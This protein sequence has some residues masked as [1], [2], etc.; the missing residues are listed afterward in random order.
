MF[1]SLLAYLNSLFAGTS[2][3]PSSNGPVDTTLSASNTSYTAPS[4]LTSQVLTITG[5]NDKVI[6]NTATLVVVA[7]GNSDAVTSS[8][9]SVTFVAEGSQDSLTLTT[10]GANAILDLTDATGGAAAATQLTATQATATL[11]N[12]TYSCNYSVCYYCGPVPYLNVNGDNNKIRLGNYSMSLIVNGVSDI[13][14]GGSGATTVTTG[15]NASGDVILGGSGAM[16]VSSAAAGVN[17]IGGTGTMNVKLTGNYDNLVTGP[18]TMVATISSIGATIETGTGNSTI[19]LTGSYATVVSGTGST[20]VVYTDATGGGLFYEGSASG[21]AEFDVA[22]SS[23]TLYG[24]DVVNA[25]GSGM[26]IMSQASAQTDLGGS[27]YSQLQF[28]GYGAAAALLPDADISAALIAAA[29]IFLPAGVTIPATTGSSGSTSSNC[30]QP[31]C[32]SGGGSGGGG[33]SNSASYRIVSLNGSNS[34]VGSDSRLMFVTVN[35]AS[36]SLYGGT[37]G[38]IYWI[39]SGELNKY[40]AGA[41]NNLIVGDGGRNVLEYFG[42]ANPVTVNIAAGTAINGYGGVDSIYNM[43]WAEIGAN[44]TA[45]G[46][47]QDATL[48]AFGSNSTL[49]GG[50]GN[51][52]LTGLGDSDTLIA[53]SGADTLNTSGQNT[54]FVIG[55]SGAIP[56]STVINSGVVGATGALS[57]L[58]AVQP[59]QIWLAADKA[60]DLVIDILGTAKS[61]TVDNWFAS[62]TQL[63]SITAAGKTLTN[64]AINSL[65]QAMASYQAAHATFDPTKATALPTDSGIQAAYAWH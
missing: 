55:K 26:R 18:G 21:Y 57:F 60:G 33:S 49:Q 35:G 25:T 50:S 6:D 44:S 48:T 58:A 29:P 56:Q 14:V 38:Q 37:A 51:D 8:S 40:F 15:A 52:T 30:C 16:T 64:A 17:V 54:S 9:T 46:G 53:G 62:G 41:G 32:G 65:E 5:S 23:S 47:R 19:N 42:A 59:G 36:N 20:K 24:G 27:N 12:T 1:Q 39:Q 3:P 4:N 11:M 2:A 13:V 7:E 31:S 63:A 61:V 28:S 10:V 45:I 34:L 22:A 43:N